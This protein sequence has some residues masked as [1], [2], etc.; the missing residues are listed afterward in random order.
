MTVKE[1]LSMLDS[2]NEVN[3][4]WDGDIVFFNFRNKI[5][6]TVWGDY[7]VDKICAAKEGVFELVLA[8]QPIKREAQ[9]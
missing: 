3:I 6:V 5:E 4:V 7:V 2:P 8:V 9:A 1:T